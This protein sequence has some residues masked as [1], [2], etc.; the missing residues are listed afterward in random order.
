MIIESLPTAPSAPEADGTPLV[1]I[2]L[3]T[4]N[5]A[6]Y[7]KPQLASLDSQVH[8]NWHLVVWDDGSTDSTPE[9]LRSF[10]DA[11]PGRVTILEGEPVRSA[12]GNF[13]RL[14]RAAPPA[15][16]Y[17]LCDQ[18]DVWHPDKLTTMIAGLQWM[19]EQHP[20]RSPALAFSDLRVVDRDLCLLR[21]SFMGQIKARPER[22]SF[23]SLIVE[24]LAPGCSMVFNSALLRELYEEPETRNAAIM[25]D[26]W[27][28]LLAISTGRVGY[29]DRALVDYRQHESN[30]LGTVTR[31]GIRFALTKL[32]K[33]NAPSIAGTY[34][35]LG[36]LL[37]LHQPQ[38]HSEASKIARAFVVTEHQT[39]I[40]RMIVCIRHGILKQTFPRRLYQL[41]KI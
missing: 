6:K 28:I 16:F 34:A 31:A 15:D 25:H 5:G 2:L 35:Q 20:I 3:A 41:L 24:N 27:L 14:L 19:G 26:W 11:R 23:G 7:L 17:A 40:A 9:L 13:F 29:V 18:D 4:F 37:S 21:E 8:N 39:K 32:L 10:A 12:S 33:P 38:M 36:A 1:V 22:A 30:T